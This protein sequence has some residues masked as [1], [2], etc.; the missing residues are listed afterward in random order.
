MTVRVLTYGALLQAD[1]YAPVDATQIPTGELA[2]WSAPRSTS[3]RPTP[4]AS[5]SPTTTSSCGS[6][7]ATTTTS[8]W[9]ALPAARSCYRRRESPTRTAGG[10]LEVRTREPGVQFYSGNQLDGTLVGTGGGARAYGR[11]AGFALETQRFPDAPN[12]PQF[13]ST[14][15]RPGQVYQTTTT[16]TTTYCFSVRS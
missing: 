12:Q 3:A 5:G 14:V 16:T 4:S 15:L 7:K 13:P 10:P 9:T 6:V 8:C 11:H 2:S 1:R